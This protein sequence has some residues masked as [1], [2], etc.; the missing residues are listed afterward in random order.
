MLVRPYSRPHQRHIL[1]ADDDRYNGG[2][3]R[4]LL[5]SDY[6]IT[7]VANGSEALDVIHHHAVDLLLA[8]IRMPV[9]DGLELLHAIRTSNNLSYLPVILISGLT[10][11][12]DVARGLAL[13][14]NDYVTKPIDQ[15][16]A[17]AR[18][19]TQM[20]LKELMD[21]HKQAIIE[22]QSVQ[23]MRDRFFN[24]ASHDLKNPMNNIRMAEFLL[25][26]YVQDEPEATMM[27][28]NIELALEA[29]QEIVANFLDTAVLQSQA[30]DLMFESVPVKDV[31]W[32]VIAQYEMTA[33]KKM[34]TLNVGDSEGIVHADPRRLQQCIGNLV[35]NA[36]K[37]SPLNAV[38]H[39]WSELTQDGVRICVGDQGPGIP[40]NEAERLFKEFGKLSTRPTAGESSTGLGLWIVK[41][42]V[43]LQNGRVGFECPPQ[44][45]TIFWVEIPY[46]ADQGAP[47]QSQPRYAS[48]A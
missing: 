40:A 19:R 24:I 30:L 34:T 10:E 16:V 47:G 15:Q 6:Q 43:V 23:Q 29:M 36:I 48:T 28:D 8:D 25:R 45:G 39:L 14:A 42:L 33:R 3:L 18:V 5:Q 37:Y 44:G 13:G 22:L 38:V 11:S 7:V 9:M 2:L 41:Q 35:S 31:I 26:N 12:E 20:Q 27:L 21:E 17:L 4:K 32:D 46:A 1:I